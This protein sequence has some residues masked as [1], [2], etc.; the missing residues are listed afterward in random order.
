VNFLLFAT[1][2]YALEIMRPLQA[3]IEASGHHAAWYFSKPVPGDWRR[4]LPVLESV[5]QVQAFDPAAVFVPGNWVPPFFPGVK[6][7]IFHGFGI[8][9][10]GHF[11]IRG[12]FDLYCTH[13]PLTTG[14]FLRL[15]REH[16]HF[17]VTETGW[18]K[19]DPLF[20]SGA[21]ADATAGGRPALLYAPTFSP[22]LTSARDL[23]QPLKMLAGSGDFDITVKFHPKMDPGLAARY[24]EMQSDHLR[25]ATEPSI[26]PLMQ[27]SA[28]LLTDTSSVV[29]E[30]LLLDKPVVTYRNAA[31]GP[32]VVD[33]ADADALARVL[34]QT[35]SGR[36]SVVERARPVAERMHPYRDGLSSRRV[37]RATLDFIDRPPAGLRPKPLNLWRRWQ[38]RRR[39][40]YYRWR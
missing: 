35:W 15:A 30:Y 13:G 3:E 21:G 7:Q 14:P 8:E 24:A 26:L 18:P 10:K 9:K 28:L 32:H 31:P 17:S 25:V 38:V 6:V 33:F 20:R 29:Y 23:L 5:Q 11:R 27:S 37:L 4:D 19:V 34:E 2:N 36:Q 39:M 22:A 12:F 1:E 16:G 40:G